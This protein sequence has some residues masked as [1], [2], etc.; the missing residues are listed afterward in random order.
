MDGDNWGYQPD[1]G[2]LDGHQLHL[3]L[4]VCSL[5]D[6]ASTASQGP[7]KGHLEIM[8]SYVCGELAF[9]PLGVP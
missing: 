6:R 4:W 7:C 1:K 3:P 5:P 2:H 8:R 9:I